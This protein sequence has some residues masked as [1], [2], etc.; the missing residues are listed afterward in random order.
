MALWPRIAWKLAR[1]NQDDLV[2]DAILSLT[3]Y[4]IS[5]KTKSVSLSQEALRIY[6]RVLAQFQERLL[7][8]TSG[9]CSSEQGSSLACLATTGICCAQFEFFSESLF[10]Y[11]RHLAGTGSILH[12]G[13][14]T[15]LAQDDTRRITL[16]HRFLRTA[17]AMVRR[18]GIVH[19]A[20]SCQEWDLNSAE[21][22]L[23]ECM[24]Y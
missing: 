13:W 21:L 6:N 19:S 14:P 11:N 24:R 16:D 15:R 18:L 12:S 23:G 5:T 9:K 8:L 7:P 2:V 10:G 1:Q 3:L 4:L 22:Q 17:C 20:F